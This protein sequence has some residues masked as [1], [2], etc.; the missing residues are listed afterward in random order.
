MGIYAFYK[1]W[2]MKTFLLVKI[3][4]L[5]LTTFSFLIPDFFISHSL[6]AIPKNYL[7]FNNFIETGLAVLI[8]LCAKG[9]S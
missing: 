2:E 1:V 7:P 5:R 4:F 3:D 9:V 6:D 8:N